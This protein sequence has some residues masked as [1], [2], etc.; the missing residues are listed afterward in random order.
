MR[1][2]QRFTAAPPQARIAGQV[3]GVVE[4]QETRGVTPVTS[5]LPQPDPHWRYTD[6]AGHEHRTVAAPTASGSWPTL[7]LLADDIYWCQE[8][9]DFHADGHWQC[10]QCSE[11]IEPGWVVDPTPAQVPGLTDTTLRIRGGRFRLGQAVTLQYRGRRWCGL[12]M[13]VNKSWI[14][15]A[16]GAIDDETTIAITPVAGH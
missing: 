8:C 1:P 13:S 7:L 11:V 15:G 6:T 4:F 14:F 5:N 9:R 3:Y 2:D 10:S 12:V 16:L